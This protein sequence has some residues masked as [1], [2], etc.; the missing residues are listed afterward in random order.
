LGR[1]GVA[2]LVQP[3]DDGHHAFE[4]G[5]LQHHVGIGHLEGLGE[6]RVVDSDGGEGA[7]RPAW[8]LDDHEEH[9][10]GGHLG[11]QRRVD[12]DDPRDRAGGFL[13]AMEDT[14]PG[15]NAGQQDDSQEEQRY[16]VLLGHDSSGDIAARL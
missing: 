3:G 8:P 9:V 15:C 5:A 14:L 16:E 4:L 10:G 13:A 2:V 6:F 1:T 12:R 11:G 7:R